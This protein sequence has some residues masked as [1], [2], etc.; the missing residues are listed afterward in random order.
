MGTTNRAPNIIR[1]FSSYS[2]ATFFTL[3]SLYFTIFKP[4]VGP[5]NR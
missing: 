1:M 5:T 2:T 4:L 3:P